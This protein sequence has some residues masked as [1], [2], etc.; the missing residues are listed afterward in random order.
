MCSWQSELL[1][2][3][4]LDNFPTQQE[5]YAQVYCV[6][7]IQGRSSKCMN[8]CS[9]FN[10]QQDETDSLTQRGKM[11]SFIYEMS[12]C[13]SFSVN[14]EYRSTPKLW[15][16]LIKKQCITFTR[17]YYTGPGNSLTCPFLLASTTSASFVFSFNQLFFISVLFS[18]NQWPLQ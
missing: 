4:V 15:N 2:P 7:I 14:T 17:S 9:Q 12:L 10:I 11:D 1:Q 8:N 18:C 13:G 3:F 5:L 16:A 6:T